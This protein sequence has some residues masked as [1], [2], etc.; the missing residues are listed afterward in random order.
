[1]TENIKYSADD[2]FY[3]WDNWA[4]DTY[5]HR[6]YVFAIS[7][8]LTNKLSEM[9]KGGGVEFAEAKM[10]I[11]KVVNSLTTE[12][13]RKNRGKYA[14]WVD[15]IK[16]NYLGAL[17]NVYIQDTSLVDSATENKIKDPE[18][19][20]NLKDTN[21][22]FDEDVLITNWCKNKFGNNWNYN[23]NKIAHTVGSYLNMQF[24]KDVFEDDFTKGK[25]EV[26]DWAKEI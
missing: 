20:K 7:V 23:L 11:Q 4:T 12:Q 6:K 1:M 13:G 19:E 15:C 17:S 2:I 18:T 10:F 24:L 22:Y 9:F 5:G 26:P 16:K 21:I 8:Q 3:K 14:G 25:T